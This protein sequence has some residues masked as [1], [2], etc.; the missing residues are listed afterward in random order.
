MKL[1]K[2][3]LG[4][5]IIPFFE[6]ELFLGDKFNFPSLSKGSFTLY[7]PSI[8][9]KDK[10]YSFKSGGHA[11]SFY[12]SNPPK[13]IVMKNKLYSAQKVPD[14]QS[15]LHLCIASFFEKEKIAQCFINEILT[16]KGDG[17]SSII[18]VKN[19]Y[20]AWDVSGCKVF[21]ANKLSEFIAEIYLNWHFICVGTNIKVEPTKYSWRDLIRKEEK[22]INFII[23]AVYDGEGFIVW[24]RQNVAI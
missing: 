15:N 7:S 14:L 9:D 3:K 22:N 19:C 8:I 10:M 1:I 20:E 11:H 17:F 4:L 21:S 12:Q 23:I 18:R 16:P 24:E 5:E 2:K 6:E 13:E